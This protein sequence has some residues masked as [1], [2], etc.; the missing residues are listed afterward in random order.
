MAKRYTSSKASKTTKT[1]KKSFVAKN[2]GLRVLDLGLVEYSQAWEM[3]KELVELRA[4]KKSPDTLLLLEHPTVVTC[5]R[6]A[7]LPADLEIP[8]FEIE[9]GGDLTLH[10]PGQI[11]GYPILYLSAENRDLHEYLRRLEEVLIR[12]LADFGLEGDRQSGLTGVWIGSRKIASIGVACRKW[13]S[14][15]GFALNVYTDLSLF[16][17]IRP[18][19]LDPA[20]MTS[21]ERELGNTPSMKA[22]KDSLIGR[23][24]EEFS[25]TPTLALG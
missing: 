2:E 9:R 8:V 19:G 12:T 7:K 24:S 10:A 15:H 16:Q 11:V 6:K 1:K 25:A 5:G 14:Y 23:F 17:T 20:I 3:Q 21:I 18:C 13:V 22:V 4:A